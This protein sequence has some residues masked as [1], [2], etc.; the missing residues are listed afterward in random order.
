MAVERSRA[1]VP[2][3]A[4]DGCPA[5]ATFRAATDGSGPQATRVR[6]L[7]ARRG[8]SRATAGAGRA[9]PLSRQRE[10][11]GAGHVPVARDGPAALVP[12]SARL[13]HADR[14]TGTTAAH[15]RR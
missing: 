10:L 13:P 7:A 2:R 5:E 12:G 11:P 14:G 9:R 3:A 4:P 15:V 8:P 6:R 1:P